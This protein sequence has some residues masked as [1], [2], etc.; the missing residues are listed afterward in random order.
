MTPAEVAR[1]IRQGIAVDDDVIDAWLSERHRRVSGRFWTP[2][3]V[4]ITAAR[5]I[6]E[7]GATRVL[8]VGSGAGKFCVTAALAADLCVTGI[9]QRPALVAD[10]RRLAR[11]LG[12]QGRTE[13]LLGTID[14]LD[15]ASFDALYIFNAF[16]ENLFF[17]P[18]R[19]D[20][21]VEL[22]VGR[23]RRDRA[24][25]ERALE[26]MAVGRALVTYHGFGGQI[27]DSFDV[28]RE[29]PL[30]TDVL[31]LWIKRRARS[32]GARWVE[33]GEGVVLCD[34][35]IAAAW[36]GFART[37]LEIVTCEEDER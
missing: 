2:V 21:T 18:E 20:D 34:A 23:M 37:P 15:L 33:M 12:V 3:A 7:S 6:A 35:P 4:A 26:R 1:A 14:A 10:A 19:L 32:T 28:A 22:S 8:D 36:R 27:P 16:A 31:R 30:G 13:L 5:W 11:R 9:E 24:L 25:V 29:E 17:A